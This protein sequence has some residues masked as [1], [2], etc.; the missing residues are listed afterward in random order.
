MLARAA[1]GQEPGQS[2]P[3]LITNVAAIRSLSPEVS[4]R[5]LPVRLQGVITYFFDERAC[6]LQDQTAG[7]FVGNGST[8]P[9]LSPGDL[10]A[11]EGTTDSGEYAPIL[12][13]SKIEILGHTNL[14]PA[15][16]VSYEELVTGR[17]DSQWVE[18]A[19]LVRAVYPEFS[20]PGKGVNLEIAVGSDRFTAF[21]PGLQASN[22]DVLVDSEVT[23]KGVCSTRFNRQHQL[24][25]ISFLL[26]IADDIMVEK[27]APVDV[28][29][30]P[31]QQIGNLMRFTVQ[32]SVY[33]RRVKVVGTVNMYQSGSALFLQDKGNG[34]YVQTH[35]SGELVPGDRVELIGFPQR[36][37]YTPILEDSVWKKIGSGPEPE[38]VL[39]RPVFALSGAHDCQLVAIEGRLLDHTFNNDELVLLLESENQ[40]FSARL[41]SKDGQGSSINL[42]NGSLLRV[43]GVCRIEVGEDWRAG[44]AW[45]AKSFIILLRSWGDVKV[46]QLPPWWNLKRLL[47]ALA[48]LIVGVVISLIWVGTLRRK[49]GQQTEMIRQQR[50][51][52]ASLKE[53]YQDLFEN[54]NDMVY[55]H[56]L[57]GQLTSI[58]VAGE[59]LIGCRREEIQQK[60]LLDFISEE[61]RPSALRWLQQ[62]IDGIPLSPVEW[63]FIPATGGRIRLEISA[64]FIEREGRPAEIEGVAR[65]VTEHRRLEKEILEISTREQRRIGHDLHDGICQQLAGICFLSEILFN[66]LDQTKHPQTEAARKL[67]GLVNAVNKE[68]RGVARGLFPVRLEENGLVS[69]LKEMTANTGAF[70]N[71]KCEFHHEAPVAINDHTVAQQLYYIAQES[72]L[73]AA[74][75]GKARLIEI[76]LKDGPD[77]C[78]LIVQDNGQGLPAKPGEPTGMGLRIMNY[79][80]RLINAT[81]RVSNRPE[82]GVEVVCQLARRSLLEGRKEAAAAI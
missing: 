41:E 21:I 67:T 23:V 54:A 7:I 8:G 80:A 79:R 39:I 47:W 68:T 14:P 17:E 2:A 24:F 82:G 78:T 22:L 44:S 38:P 74:K 42:E 34:L 59:S 36:G 35:Q 71:T 12:R 76:F 81:L 27:P 53:R 62:I 60:N 63:D 61:Q 6:F 3:T 4:A 46:L 55:T 51:V 9:H 40:A 65:D 52:E 69:A 32:P 29:S 73:N 50:D 45:H 5:Q 58:N 26:P 31:A 20:E 11:V 30:Q 33:G 15:R 56:D 49:V 37:E 19:G 57:K 66:D 10:V 16:R 1:G 13:P 28:F 18:I 48:V 25:S 43:T 77:L 72:V 64:R 75:H 70:F